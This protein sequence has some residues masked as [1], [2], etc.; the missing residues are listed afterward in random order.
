MF[1]VE[2]NRVL[3]LDALKSLKPYIGSGKDFV[4]NKYVFMEAWVDQTT[5][6]NYLKLVAANSIDICE[7]ITNVP[8]CSDGILPL[9]EFN[10]FNDLINAIDAPVIDINT[11]GTNVL[12]DYLGGGEPISLIGVDASNFPGFPNHNV[13]SSIIM[14]FDMFSNG[15]MIAGSII[16]QD[17]TYPL[18]NCVNITVKQN[19]MLFESVDSKYRRMIVYEQNTAAGKKEGSFFAEFNRLKKICQNNMPQGTDIQI[20]ITDNGIIFS[21]GAM[22]VFTRLISG[23]FPDCIKLIPPN[24]VTTLQFDRLDLMS[25][26]DRAKVLVDDKTKTVHVRITSTT[27]DPAAVDAIEISASSPYGSMKEYVAH[28]NFSGKD[29]DLNFKVESLIDGLKNIN[30]S[31]VN[32]MFPNLNT[33]IFNASSANGNHYYL[34][35]A[36]RQ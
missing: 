30:D 15:V 10:R 8:A 1:K 25:V 2:M 29:L 31:T 6:T 12:I 36:V 16:S 22:R 34:T 32:W 17:D 13:Q 14:P 24:F 33:S 5:N 9:V 18:Y 3:L 28:K 7:I 21:V 27:N 4:F 19:S 11:D 26:L 35:P 20:D 23:N